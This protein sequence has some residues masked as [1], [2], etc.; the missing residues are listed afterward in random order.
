MAQ[1]PASEIQALRLWVAE[2][3][4][5]GTARLN[6]AYQLMLISETDE[7]LK[8]YETLIRQDPQNASAAEGILWALQS[9]N[10]FRES[11]ARAEGLLQSFPAHAPLYNYTAYGL[12]QLNLHLAARQLYA[13]A[14]ELA[15]N[16]TQRNTANLGLAWEYLIL[17]NYPAAKSALAKL[18][19][20]AY[21]GAKANR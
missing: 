6:L 18:K 16:D 3:P 1:S 4:I 8:H 17:K 14:T 13:K 20:N 10:R 5:D 21:P 15:I 19:D 9:Q 12:S 7:A 2:N 11:S